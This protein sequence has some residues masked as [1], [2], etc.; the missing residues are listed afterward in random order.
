MLA[1]TALAA[2]A[3]MSPR[4][5]SHLERG[6]ARP[7]AGTTARLAEALSLSAPDRA[8]FEAAA[9]AGLPDTE[10]ERCLAEIAQQYLAA[11]DEAAA[12]PYALQA[13]DHAAAL[14]APEEAERLYRLAIQLASAQGDARSAAAAQLKLGQLLTILGSSETGRQFIASALA[15]FRALD[16]GE[17][18]VHAQMALAINLGLDGRVEETLAHLLAVRDLV[19]PVAP[20]R[21]VAHVYHWLSNAYVLISAHREELAAAERARTY[22]AQSGDPLTRAQAEMRYGSALIRQGSLEAGCTTIECSLPAA[23][24][25]GD[26][27][28]YGA[29]LWTLFDAYLALGRFA[30]A[31]RY[32]AQAS[33]LA[34]QS[35]HSV[36]NAGSAW[37]RGVLAFHTGAWDDAY[38]SWLEAVTASR[39]GGLAQLPYYQIMLAHLRYLRGER[40]QALHAQD[41][42]DTRIG[43]RSR[44]WLSLA[45][46]AALASQDLLEN[47]PQAALGRLEPRLEPLGDDV[48]LDAAPLLPLLAEAYHCV[49]DERRAETTVRRALARARA[50]PHRL[51]LVDALRMHALLAIQRGAWA[52]AE[53]AV[54]EALTLARALPCPYAEAKTLSLLGTLHATRGASERARERHEAALAIF[55]RLG[56]RPHAQLAEQALEEL[57]A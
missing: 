37:L 3:Q 6:L 50:M 56:E 49:G 43:T 12:L 30:T 2:R 57:G 38:A 34:T 14:H 5:I 28:D 11:G 24:D 7:D 10:R 27:T 54:E 22:A 4:T 18:R 31:G 15:G 40:E 1:Q 23:P 25:I 52:E 32:L 55:K 8:R 9:L 35:G 42:A 19:E 13:G 16:D 47:R 53:R 48:H 17:G 29:V 33:E 26:V 20:A 46:D 45:C 44:L 36:G 39:A 51:M 21:E 41:E